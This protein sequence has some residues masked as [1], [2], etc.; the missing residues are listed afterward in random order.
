MALS[1]VDSGDDYPCSCL[2][3][4]DRLTCHR[5]LNLDHR[6]GTIDQPLHWRIA[7]RRG[8]LLLDDRHVIGLWNDAGP[9]QRE[10]ASIQHAP[11]KNKSGW[12]SRFTI[13]RRPVLAAQCREAALW[14]HRIGDR[15]IRPIFPGKST[16]HR[17]GKGPRS[18]WSPDR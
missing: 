3:L 13:P 15:C 1:R 8:Y 10:Q 5:F 11:G 7:N 17:Q 6:P 12:L 16:A 18:A 14:P 4:S 9:G 2:S